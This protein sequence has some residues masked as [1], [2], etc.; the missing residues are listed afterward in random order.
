MLTFQESG[1]APSMRVFLL[2]RAAQEVTSVGFLTFAEDRHQFMVGLGAKAANQI[3]QLFE[4]ADAEEA[5]LPKGLQTLQG[6]LEPSIHVSDGPINVGF[7]LLELSGVMVETR[8]LGL[9]LRQVD[10]AFTFICSHVA[11]Y[12]GDLVRARS[13]F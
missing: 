4:T 9:W 12:S 7:D 8:A 5:I 3:A 13:V 1:D 2:H 10:R 6:M 11:S